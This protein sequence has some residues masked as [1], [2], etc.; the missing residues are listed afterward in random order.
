MNRVSEK[1]CYVD[2]LTQD[3]SDGA[4]SG[5]A[6]GFGIDAGASCSG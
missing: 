4:G 5:A 2:Q 3:A 1:H 6:V